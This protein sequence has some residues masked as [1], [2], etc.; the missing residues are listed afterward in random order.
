MLSQ[1]SGMPV[2]SNTASMEGSVPL[3]TRGLTPA[4]S[5][6]PSAEYDIE[7]RSEDA[8]HWMES[9]SPAAVCHS[10]VAF[11]KCQSLFSKSTAASSSGPR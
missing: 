3:C 2:A 4:K 1:F 9:L 7:K 11:A 6:V 5:V 10:L 8:N